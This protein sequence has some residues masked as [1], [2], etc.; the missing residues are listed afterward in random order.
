MSDEKTTRATNPVR[1]AVD[2]SGEQEAIIAATGFPASWFTG[3]SV[4]PLL[5]IGPEFASMGDAN[6][7]F[8]ENGVPDASFQLV[9]VTKRD[10]R[11]AQKRSIVQGSLG[12]TSETE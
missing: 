8:L 10:M 4:D 5:M 11:I 1:W 7:W 3:E 6:A 12:L 9:R 2:V